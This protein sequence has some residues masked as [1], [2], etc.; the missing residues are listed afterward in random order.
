[1]HAYLVN[2]IKPIEGTLHGESATGAPH[3][4]ESIELFGVGLCHATYRQGG[5]PT[6]GIA[7]KTTPS[8]EKNIGQWRAKH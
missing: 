5:M 3:T 7:A 2:P 4:V 1:M 8:V 6:I